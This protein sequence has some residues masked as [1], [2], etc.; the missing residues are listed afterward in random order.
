MAHPEKEGQGTIH[1]PPSTA[2][3]WSLMLLEMPEAVQPASQHYSFY[4]SL[5]RNQGGHSFMHLPGD[6]A[7]PTENCGSVQSCGVHEVVAT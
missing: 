2:G 3:P 5:L 1:Y 4:P 7:A 6:S